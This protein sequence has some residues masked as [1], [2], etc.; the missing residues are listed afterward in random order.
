MVVF[1]FDESFVINLLLDGCSSKIFNALKAQ[2]DRFNHPKFQHLLDTA[3][4][5][6]IYDRYYLDD[7]YADKWQLVD[8][9][10]RRGNELKDLSALLSD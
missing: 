10:I 4:H 8:L 3:Y 7:D 5:C 2:C 1:T 9:A 6:E